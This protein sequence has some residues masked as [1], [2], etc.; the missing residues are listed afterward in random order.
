ME[1]HN[2]HTTIAFIPWNYDRNQAQTVAL[3]RSHPERFSICIHGNDHD[4]K[5]F[6]DLESKPLQIQVG[7]LKQSLARM[8]K[9]QALTGIPYDNVF[10]FPHSIGT[11][12][13]LK[14]LKTY[15]FLATINST[16][17]PMDGK[18]PSGLLFPLRPVTLSFADFA[19]ISRYT[20][21]MT[22]PNS[23][24]GINEFL[25]NPVF[26]Y[27][28]HDFFATGIGAFDGMADAVN[29]SEPDTR[30]RSAGE[31]VKH[32]YLIRLREDANYDVLAFSNSVELE[33][34]STRDLV[35][36]VIRPEF[37]SQAI[38]SVNVDGR[39]YPYELH[40]GDL[41]LSVPVPAGSTRSLV[42]QYKNDLD[43]A[44][45]STAR[46]SVRVDVLRMV[47]DFRDITLSKFYVGRALTDYYYKHGITPL[48]IIV[49]GGTF[50]LIIAGGVW[51][52]HIVTKRKK[53]VVV[54]RSMVTKD[55]DKVAR[56]AGGG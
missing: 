26:F 41:S 39:T 29:K 55:N 17:I 51:I 36:Y 28:H 5:E 43:L 23:F 3:V 25:D 24:L 45:V 54:S 11:E 48:L 40:A 7:D 35:F 38:A 8:A 18:R 9:F 34:P 10:V 1:Q 32:L 52:L 13:V 4:H 31:I 44:S 19:S 16:N 50:L 20:A 46:D 42:I 21:G 30:W 14:E 15:N 49:F 12:G 56:A 22:N 2:F 37:G 53:P 27:T 47:S 6:E 33:N